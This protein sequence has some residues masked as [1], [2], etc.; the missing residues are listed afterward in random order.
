MYFRVHFLRAVDRSRR[1]IARSKREMNLFDMKIYKSSSFPIGSILYSNYE[2]KF[3]SICQSQSVLHLQRSGNI[4]NKRI[5]MNLTF[6]IH[7]FFPCEYCFV[8]LRVCVLK[9]YTLTSIVSIHFHPNF[10]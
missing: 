8:L 6:R 7:Q 10:V 3:L 1:N 5:H 4:L 9:N 2:V